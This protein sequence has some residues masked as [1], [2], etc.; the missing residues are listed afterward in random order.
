LQTLSQLKAGELAG[1]QRLALSENLTSFPI[2]ILSLADSLE[3]LDLSNNQLTSLP[4]ELMQL[5]KL[6]IIFAS[7]NLFETLPEVLGQCANLEMVGFKANNI[8]QVPDNALPA[9][10]RWLILT[11]NKIAVLP[12]TLG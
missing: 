1:V 11:D 9:K 3:I 12:D 5:S 7:N 10:L 2:E 4:Q 6:K 8:N